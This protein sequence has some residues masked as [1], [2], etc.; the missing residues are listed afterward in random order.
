MAQFINWFIWV[1]KSPETIQ[2]IHGIPDVIIPFCKWIIP[3]C[4]E[5]ENIYLAELKFYSA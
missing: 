1:S 5:N 2:T 3:I 4:S